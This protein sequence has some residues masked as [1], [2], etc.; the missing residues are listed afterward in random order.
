MNGVQTSTLSLTLPF[1]FAD[2]RANDS[3]PLEA[4]VG[5]PSEKP[6]HGSNLLSSEGSHS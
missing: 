5:L 4:L 6:T 2:E 1:S 3:R